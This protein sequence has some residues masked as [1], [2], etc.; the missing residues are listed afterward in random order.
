MADRIYL[1]SEDGNDKPKLVRANT[2]AQ[3]IR[4]VV[5]DKFKA[6]VPS[7]DEL[8]NALKSGAIVEDA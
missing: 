7:Q 2:P 5:Q 8:V 6:A 3:A 4:H 1:V